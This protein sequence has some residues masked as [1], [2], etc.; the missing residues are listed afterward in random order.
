MFHNLMRAIAA[1]RDTQG[2]VWSC[3][4]FHRMG[5]DIE[6]EQGAESVVRPYELHRHQ[7]SG[8]VVTSARMQWIKADPT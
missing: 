3:W 8:A 7:V 2:S 6:I 5:R 4:P 1:F